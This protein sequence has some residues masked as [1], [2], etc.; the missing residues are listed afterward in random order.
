[1]SQITSGNLLNDFLAK[2]PA[3]ATKDDDFD[4]KKELK[5]MRKVLQDACVSLALQGN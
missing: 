5:G 2:A 3:R 4:P 1:M